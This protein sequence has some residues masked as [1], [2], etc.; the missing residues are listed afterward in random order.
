MVCFPCNPADHWRF[1]RVARIG[2][3]AFS[4]FC[5]FVP[6]KFGQEKA[7]VKHHFNLTRDNREQTRVAQKLYLLYL[8]NMVITTICLLHMQTAE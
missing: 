4:V 1:R 7:L 3:V 2:T 5:G 8:K 6:M